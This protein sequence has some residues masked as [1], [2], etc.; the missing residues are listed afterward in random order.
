MVAV[1]VL[2]LSSCSSGGGAVGTTADGEDIT[3]DDIFD[4]IDG[5][6]DGVVTREEF[7]SG[8]LAADRSAIIAVFPGGSL[9][10]DEVLSSIEESP[11]S[12]LSPGEE[13]DLSVIV[14]RLTL[15][16]RLRISAIALTDLGFEVSLDGTDE[17]IAARV[18]ETVSG[19]FEQHAM[20][21]VIAER[22]EVIKIAAPHC[23]SLIA[24]PTEAEALDAIARIEGGESTFDV[25][26]EVNF[27]NTTEEGGGLGC[28]DVLTWQQNIGPTAESLGELEEGEMS[29]PQ[30]VPVAAS[31]TGELWVFIHVDEVLLELSDPSTLGPFAGAPITDQMQTYLVEIDPVLG[32]WNSEGLAISLPS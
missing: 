3:R 4:E 23:L 17:E 32:T 12:T 1:F 10:M 13:P 29:E 8:L 5:D 20:E 19:P 2:L 22:P 27:E 30:P 11:P 18:N 14:G 16:L 31:E 9:T 7:D 28:N 26:V 25:A 21:Q 6:D 24:V 15:M